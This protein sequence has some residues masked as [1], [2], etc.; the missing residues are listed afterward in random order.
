[1]DRPVKVKKVWVLVVKLFKGTRQQIFKAFEKG[2]KKTERR[3]KSNARRYSKKWGVPVY[4]SL[5]TPLDEDANVSISEVK[6][7]ERR[8]ERLLRLGG[9]EE[10][11]ETE[12]G[13]TSSGSE[14]RI[15][16]SDN[17]S[18]Q[19]KIEAANA[20]RGLTQQEW[21]RRNG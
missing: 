19:E 8:I 10:S 2:D 5:R 14:G 21:D 13:Q 17:G 11:K 1:M 16:D 4:A 18:A 6:N 12:E 15:G 7:N 9:T 20:P 3:A